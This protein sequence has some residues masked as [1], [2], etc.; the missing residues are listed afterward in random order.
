[1]G[2]QNSSTVLSTATV[3]CESLSEFQTTFSKESDQCIRS[4]TQPLPIIVIESGWTKSWLKLHPDMKL[5]RWFLLNCI[6]VISILLLLLNPL[7]GIDFNL[8]QAINND[9]NGQTLIIIHYLDHVSMCDER[10]HFIGP[11]R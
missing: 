4:G 5:W 8:V 3:D 6:S 7:L 11:H 10:L 9:N 2:G 1:M